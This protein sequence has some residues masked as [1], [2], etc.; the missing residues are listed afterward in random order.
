MEA[1]DPDEKITFTPDDIIIK[2]QAAEF[3]KIRIVSRSL[4]LINIVQA[5]VNV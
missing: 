1:A 3:D 5:F 4:L 2:I